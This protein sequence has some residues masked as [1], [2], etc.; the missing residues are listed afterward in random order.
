MD[1]KISTNLTEIELRKRIYAMIIPITLESI[2]QMSSGIIAMGMIGR[3]DTVS[4]AAVG[5]STRITQ[6]IW[7]LFRGVTT[8]ATVFVAQAYGAND[9]G[10]LRKIVQQTLL[11]SILVVLA[12]QQLVFWKAPTLLSIFGK[13]NPLLLENSALYLRTISFGL[14]F[15]AIMLVVTGVLQGTG[16]AKTPMKIAV[17]M[18]IINIALNYGLIYGELGLP[19]LGLKGSAIATATAQFVA[20]MI[21]LYILFNKRGVLGFR[22]DSNLYKINFKQVWEIYRVGGPTSFESMFWQVSAIILTKIILSFGET[23]L[24][25]Y[26]LG[27]QVESISFMPAAGFGVAATAFIGQALG[28]KDPQLSRRYLR[29]IV[30]GSMVLTS[31]STAILIF[32]PGKAMALLTDQPEVIAL[33]ATYLLFMGLVQVPQNLAG[34]L[35]GAMRGAGYTRVPMIVAGAGL[36]GIRIPCAWILTKYFGWGITTIWA[37]MAVDL[38][39]RCIL[40][41]TL[42]KRYNIYEAEVIYQQVEA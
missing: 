7:A 17:I 32:L 11:S 13:N 23:A 18:N 33:G 9:W 39:V 2:L 5:L 26:Q 42:F 3:I 34:V 40:S 16:N 41:L 8:G 10:K 29:E 37:T 1:T 19:A 21:G 38:V 12:L 25:A 28:A 4:V 15:L 22:I 24:A 31:I 27:F 14:P 20:A 30:K 6:I 36:W 35:N